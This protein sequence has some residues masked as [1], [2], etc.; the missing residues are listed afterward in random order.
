MPNEP[1]TSPI[2]IFT[3]IFVHLNV[4]IWEG[5][6]SP[7]KHNP[8]YGLAHE[9]LRQTTH[10]VWIG[11]DFLCQTIPWAQFGYKI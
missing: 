5:D 9:N 1:K 11:Y 3:V 4:V 2:Y 8:G 6:I 10:K 7:T